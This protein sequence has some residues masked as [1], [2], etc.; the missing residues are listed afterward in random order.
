MFH[1]YPT[2]FDVHAMPEKGPVERLNALE[3]RVKARGTA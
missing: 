2:G 3:S 1:D